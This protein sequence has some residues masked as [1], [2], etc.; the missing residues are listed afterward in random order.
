MAGPAVH[1]KVMAGPAVYESVIAA[2][3]VYE[4]V[5]AGF[6]PATHDFITQPAGLARSMTSKSRSRT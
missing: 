3:A 6:S 2:P 5:M 4:S 1:E